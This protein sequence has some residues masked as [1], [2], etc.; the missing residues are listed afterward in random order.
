MFNRW[1]FNKYRLP[2]WLRRVRDGLETMILPIAC[3]QLLRT[4]MLPTTFDVI[5]LAILVSLYICFLKRWL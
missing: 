4:I 5:L 1:T 2:P 3:F